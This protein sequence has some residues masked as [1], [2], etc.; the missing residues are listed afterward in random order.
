ML[1]TITNLI[2]YI[3]GLN[4]PFLAITISDEGHLKVVPKVI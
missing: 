1:L 3:L 4:I 2:N